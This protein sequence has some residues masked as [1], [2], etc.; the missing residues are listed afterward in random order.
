M[1]FGSINTILQ[2]VEAHAGQFGEGEKI[3]QRSFHWKA[4]YVNLAAVN[5]VKRRLCHVGSD[6]PELLS[7]KELC[8]H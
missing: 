5:T 7:R 3:R 4:V 8:D 2:A 6:S 1:K